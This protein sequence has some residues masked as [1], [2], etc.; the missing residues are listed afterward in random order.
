MLPAL[1]RKA[2]EALLVGADVLGLVLS[3]SGASVVAILGKAM[4]AVVL[5]AMALGF[6]LR[7]S[8][9]RKVQATL[10]AAPPIWSRPASALI[11]SIEVALLVEA[12]NLPVR[13]HQPGFEPWHWALVAVALA[14]AYWLHMRLFRTW[15]ARR[16]VR[17]SLDQAADSAR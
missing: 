1:K 11:A 4:L 2:A 9:R 13:F 16:N 8:G 6:F 17:R 10:P 14:L 15:A 5:L 7:L 12:T 3:A